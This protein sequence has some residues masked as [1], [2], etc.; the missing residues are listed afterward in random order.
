MDEFDLKKG[1]FESVAYLQKMAIIHDERCHVVEHK[2]S[3]NSGLKETGKRRYAG[4]RS[5][6]DNS[7]GSS[8]GGASNKASDQ[9]NSG[10]GRLSDSTGTGMQ[11]NRE[12]SPCLNTKKCAGEKH[13]LSDC[14]HSGKDEAIVLLSEHKKKMDT[15]KKKASLKTLGNS[16]AT[17]DN[18]DGQIAYL[19]AENLEVKVT[20]LK[21]T[22]SD[23]FSIPRSAVEDAIK[24]GF[25]LK[26]E[27]LPEPVMLSMDIRDESDKQKCSAKEILKS[28]MTITKPSG[29]MCMRG[30]RQ[31]IVEEEN[32]PFID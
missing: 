24:R 1:F 7:G 17:A 31:I 19:M 30:V 2:K 18:R 28:A 15:D 14:P 22:G 3:G 11:S 26:V 16:G 27:V 25:P 10:H 29:P 6:G 12:P 13:Y 23:Y 21:D 32:G 4:S 8:H 5:S 20:V 9:T